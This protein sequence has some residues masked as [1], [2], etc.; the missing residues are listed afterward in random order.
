MKTAYIIGTVVLVAVGA[1]AANFFIRNKNKEDNQ[2][3][4]KL[5]SLKIKNFFR[6]KPQ[7]EIRE[8]DQLSLRVFGSWIKEH[9]FPTFTGYKF[10]IIKDQNLVEKDKNPDNLI[11]HG[12]CIT[13]S[14]FNVIDA[15]VYMSKEIDS[16]FASK[17]IEEVNEI[18]IK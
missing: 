10:F 12:F 3:T 14:E 11:V 4:S 9:D 15:C 6:I 18:V 1:V 8:T 13:D 16:S 2:K 7:I 5:S 17:V